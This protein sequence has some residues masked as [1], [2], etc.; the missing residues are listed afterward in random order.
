[1]KTDKLLAALQADLASTSAVR[2]GGGHYVALRGARYL[3]QMLEGS[4]ETE[5]ESDR[6]PVWSHSG[7][8]D[9][10]DYLE[11]SEWLTRLVNFNWLGLGPVSWSASFTLIGTAE[12]AWLAWW[13]DFSRYRA[14]AALQGADDPEVVAAAVRGALLGSPPF[15]NSVE[16]GTLPDST[17][18]WSPEL[19]SH[20]SLRSTFKEFLDQGRREDWRAFVDRCL[21]RGLEPN[22]LRLSKQVLE[23]AADR[24]QRR[25]DGMT[26]PPK[27]RGK[28]PSLAVRKACFNAFF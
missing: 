15:S 26:I 19:L 6:Y 27:D 14:V 7:P 8:P 24:Y 22:H 13:D 10:N 2:V 3:G 23:A 28:P 18:I 1:M 20:S 25:A 12:Q 11:A 21:A 5:D 4:H 9:I 17:D 16:V